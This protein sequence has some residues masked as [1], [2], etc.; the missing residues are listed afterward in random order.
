VQKIIFVEADLVNA[1]EPGLVPG[2]SLN[3]VGTH[4]LLAP[5]WS[6]HMAK[7]PSQ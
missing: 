5:I 3:G 1:A 4:V 7:P 2:I 6:V